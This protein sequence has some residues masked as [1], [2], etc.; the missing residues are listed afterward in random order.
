MYTTH[1]SKSTNPLSE[2]N[3]NLTVIVVGS[4]Q[5][6]LFTLLRS[7]L[8]GYLSP[9]HGMACPQVV[10]R[11]GLQIWR[12]AVKSNM[13]SQL[14]SGG[15]SAWG[16]DEGLTTPHPKKPACYRMLHRA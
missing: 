7:M 8:C 11:D 12:V 14:R 1:M 9:W 6:N 4:N 2:P 15:P 10:H 13:H 5:N 3:H 16:L